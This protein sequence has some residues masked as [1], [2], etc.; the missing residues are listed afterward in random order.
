MTQLVIIYG[1]RH[2]VIIYGNRHA[3]HYIPANVLLLH[4]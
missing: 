1:N 2:A 3:V 4:K